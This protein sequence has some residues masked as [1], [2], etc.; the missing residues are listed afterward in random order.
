MHFTTNESKRHKVQ[1]KHWQ[2]LLYHSLLLMVLKLI[3]NLHKCINVDKRGNGIK[4]SKF[5]I[6]Q[7]YLLLLLLVTVLKIVAPSSTLYIFRGNGERQ[8]ATLIQPWKMVL[9]CQKCI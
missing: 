5:P 1:R 3:I 4:G 6:T 9:F 8:A 2:C 7:H